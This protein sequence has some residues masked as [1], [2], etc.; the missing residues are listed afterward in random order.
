ML[1]HA[2]QELES[3]RHLHQSAVSTAERTENQ[4]Q[5]V[6]ERGFSAEQSADQLDEEL[7]ELAI[8]VTALA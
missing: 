8:R 3:A 5:L 1:A 4:L 2:E 7:R 6:S